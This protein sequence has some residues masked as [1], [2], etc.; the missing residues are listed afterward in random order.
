MVVMLVMAVELNMM[1][2]GT[3]LVT[4]HKSGDRGGNKQ[5][6]FGA[7]LSKWYPRQ[8]LYPTLDFYSPCWPGEASFS[9]HLFF[10]SIATASSSYTTF[11]IKPPHFNYN[12]FN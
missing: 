5:T 7:Q 9:M 10:Q 4:R 8:Y 3:L 2:E 12:I 6:I 1:E 11:T